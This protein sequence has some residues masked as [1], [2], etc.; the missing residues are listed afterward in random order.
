MTRLKKNAR[1]R[2]KASQLYDSNNYVETRF[3]CLAIRFCSACH[4]HQCGGDYYSE[5]K[6]LNDLSFS[7]V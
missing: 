7:C 3:G 1:V 4:R 5:Q 6:I 2:Q